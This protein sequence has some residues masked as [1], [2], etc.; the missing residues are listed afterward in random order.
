[1]S[2]G[3]APD[4]ARP[5][6]PGRS[7]GGA[8]MAKQPVFDFFEKVIVTSAD[9]TK[10]EIRG[11][12]GAV[13]GRACGDDGLWS[14]AVSMY[15]TKICWSCYEHELQSTGEFD[16]RESFYDGTSIRVSPKGKLLG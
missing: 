11:Q 15:H 4:P 6:E 5:A 7:G 13:L 3:T 1:M 10:A 8:S 14:Y 9:P 12:L 16:R 2:S